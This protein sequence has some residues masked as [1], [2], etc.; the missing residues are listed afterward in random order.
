MILNCDYIVLPHSQFTQ[1]TYGACNG[2][3]LTGSSLRV[4][5]NR[6]TSQLNIT[7][8]RE[9]DEQNIECVHDSGTLLT[10]GMSKVKLKGNHDN[11]KSQIKRR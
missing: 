6:Y 5:N 3:A 2:G 10:V 11:L 4:E 1:G 7:I 8:S 9:L